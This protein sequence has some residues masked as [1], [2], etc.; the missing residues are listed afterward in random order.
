M[1]LQ[2]LGVV[3]AGRINSLGIS[4]RT[5]YISSLQI[6]PCICFYF[7]LCTL[8][9]A[10]LNVRMLAGVAGLDGAHRTRRCAW[11]KRGTWARAASS[12]GQRVNHPLVGGHELG[13]GAL[14]ASDAALDKCGF[15]CIGPCPADGTGVF[16]CV[17]SRS[18]ACPPDWAGTPR[19]GRSQKRTIRRN[20]RA[21]AFGINA[22]MPGFGMS[23]RVAWKKQPSTN[24]I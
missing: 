15:S 1:N 13:T 8:N 7:A 23:V 9:F 2:K 10:L 18:A 4:K 19:I 11:I 20:V 17:S 6:P 12:E 22:F 21:S 5:R 16:H 24:F 3:G 14:I